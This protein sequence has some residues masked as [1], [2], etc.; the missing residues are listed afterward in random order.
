L[1][2]WFLGPRRTRLGAAEIVTHVTLRRP[3]PPHGAAFLKLARY[4]GE[5]LAQASLTVVVTADLD[6][7][8]AFGAVAPTPIRSHRIENLLRGHEP[9][10]ELTA[11][12]S[13]LV[14]SEVSPI[15]DMRATR[16]YR[17]HMCRVMLE[18]GVEAAL[19]RRAGAGPDY[20]ARLV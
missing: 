2:E 5:D 6:Y 10:G 14:T 16:E 9:D 15:T 18:R 20:P 13:M 12:A 7:R 11:Q 19:S 17:L 1:T 8:L 4:S 3:A